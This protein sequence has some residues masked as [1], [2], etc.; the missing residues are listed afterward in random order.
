MCTETVCRRLRLASI[1]DAKKKSISRFV[2]GQISGLQFVDLW[3]CESKF[4]LFA[5][6]L[7]TAQSSD[8]EIV[9]R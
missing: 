8:A 9:Q 2:C 1:V 4:E 5:S 3:T 7:R 6:R